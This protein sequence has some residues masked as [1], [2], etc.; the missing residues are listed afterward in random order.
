[1]E[2]K[3]IEINI[4]KGMLESFTVY[5]DTETN[6]KNISATIGLYTDVNK[7][8]TQYSIDTRNYYGNKIEFPISTYPAINKICEELEL[9]TIRHCREGQLCL[10]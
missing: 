8:I 2:N 5:I 3:Q 9:A 7:K 10:K 4:T 1:M 6:E